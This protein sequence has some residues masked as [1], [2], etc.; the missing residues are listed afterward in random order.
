[1]EIIFCCY[2]FEC[3]NNLK[4]FFNK[5]ITFDRYL[6]KVAEKD[7][8]HYAVILN[9]KISNKLFLMKDTFEKLA[10]EII[11]DDTDKLNRVV[12]MDYYPE[13]IEEQ[14]AKQITKEEICIWT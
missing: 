11:E 14:K 2:V 6:F 4:S 8:N 13:L 1:M 10:N 7:E 3:A 5:Q 12:F 9:N